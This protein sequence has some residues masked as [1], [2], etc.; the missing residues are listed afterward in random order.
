MGKQVWQ[1]LMNFSFQNGLLLFSLNMTLEM[2]TFLYHLK[3][4]KVGHMRLL[5]CAERH[6]AGAAG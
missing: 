3:S 4:P 2:N 1:T 5:S 6:G